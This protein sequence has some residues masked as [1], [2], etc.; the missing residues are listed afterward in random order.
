LENRKN[1]KKE[2]KNIENLYT[3]GMLFYT[4]NCAS[5][6]MGYTEQGGSAVP[7]L[8]HIENKMNKKQVLEKIKSGGSV[9]P[10][11][12]NIS[13]KHAQAILAYLFHEHNAV[14]HNSS[15][16]N[17]SKI[18]NKTESLRESNAMYFPRNI[19][20]YNNPTAYGII[21][22]KNGYPAVKPPWG[23]LSAI[24]INS[25][26]FVW[27][28]TLGNHPELK[29][30]IDTLTGALNF[31]GPIVTGGGLLFIGATN[32]DKFRAFDKKTGK[33]LWQTTLKGW[34]RATPI[35]YKINGKQFVVISLSGSN[36]GKPVDSIVA[37]SLPDRSQ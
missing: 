34:G 18:K 5:Y 15:E 2:E 13:S 12:A 24:N 32:D 30:K 7:A 4:N 16:F 23:T 22:D 26:D 3:Q 6:V 1:I 17:K 35:T 29:A 19:P 33:L 27:N 14:L 8:I 25:G 31:G 11:F 28:I 20:K 10:A 36:E 37:F 9:M 21:K